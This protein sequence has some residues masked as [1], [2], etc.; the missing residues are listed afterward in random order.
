VLF[1]HT[2]GIV[3]CGRCRVADD[4]L[5]RMRG[6]L[7][8]NSLAGGEGILL[9][10]AGM[11]HTAF[12][13]FPIDAVFLDSNGIVLGIRSDLGPWRTARVKGARAVLELAAGETRW[14]GLEVGDQLEIVSNEALLARQKTNHLP[15]R[16]EN[17]AEPAGFADLQRR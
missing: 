7:G 4:P 16:R 14:R 6:L 1:K 13:R 9:R 8:R 12:M 5:T 15:P 10:P 3:L 11:I 17:E 2:A